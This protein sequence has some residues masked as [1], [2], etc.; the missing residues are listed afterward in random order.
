MI[1]L[2]ETTRTIDELKAM[3][4]RANR[5]PTE[6]MTI[7]EAREWSVK[8]DFIVNVSALRDTYWS[9]LEDLL[10]EQTEIAEDKNDRKLASDILD[11]MN[12]LDNLY[13]CWLGSALEAAKQRKLTK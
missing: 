7:E 4:Q 13:I 3:Q 1:T 5:Y 8:E 10:I 11:I 6:N 2:N 9:F 12:D